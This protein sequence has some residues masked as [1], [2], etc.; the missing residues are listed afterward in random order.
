MAKEK[1]EVAATVPM[2]TTVTE[3]GEVEVLS[4]KD[5][6]KAISEALDVPPESGATRDIAERMNEK[7][8]GQKLHKEALLADSPK[9]QAEKKAAIVDISPDAAETPSGAALKKVAG[10]SDNVLRGLHYAYEKAIRRWAPPEP[11]PE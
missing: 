5:A 1:V 10:I 9:E 7:D 4:G 6:R 3:T 8:E 2:G 11:P